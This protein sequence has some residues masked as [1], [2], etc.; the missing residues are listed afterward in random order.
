MMSDIWR[1]CL[2]RLEGEFSV[3]DMHTY[4][5]P[6]QASEDGDGLRLLAPNAYTLEFVR[7]KFQGLIERVLTHVHGAPIPLRLEVG[8][9][10]SRRVEKLGTRA[11]AAEPDDFEHNLDPH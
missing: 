9:L 7:T 10:A 8:T 3:E 11:G 4:L 2:E 6:L 1:R 5:M